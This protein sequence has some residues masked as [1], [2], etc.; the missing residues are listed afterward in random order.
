[1]SRRSRL[2]PAAFLAAALIGFGLGPDGD[3]PADAAP[4]VTA[5]LQGLDKITAR[6]STI[7]APL[8]KEVSFGDLRIVVR[9]CQKRPP[10][11]PPESAAFL[12][13]REAKPGKAATLLFSGWMFASSPAVSALDHPV[14]DVWVLDCKGEG[15][16]SDDVKPGAGK[17]GGK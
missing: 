12:E 5:V 2:V 4:Q 9:A 10:E 13:I 14:Y 17:P 6:I 1:M 15:A 3:R 8:D 11:E 7:E 16:V